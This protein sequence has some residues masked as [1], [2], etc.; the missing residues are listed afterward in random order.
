MHNSLAVTVVEGLEE[1]VDVISYIDVVEFG[2]ETSE[3]RVV[4]VLE[5]QR[6]SLTLFSVCPVSMKFS[7]LEYAWTKWCPT[8]VRMGKG[9]DCY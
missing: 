1:F 7:L 2:I 4:H 6:W 5:N 8:P 9:K 3:V